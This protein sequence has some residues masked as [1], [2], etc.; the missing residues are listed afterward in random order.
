MRSI[1]QHMRLV[2]LKNG[3]FSIVILEKNNE[4]S[5]VIPAK[6]GIHLVVFI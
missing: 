1:L 5:S 2:R 4:K 3:Y 6:A